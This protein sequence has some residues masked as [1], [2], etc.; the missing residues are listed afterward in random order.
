MVHIYII[1]LFYYFSIF[2]IIINIIV[3]KYQVFENELKLVTSY[4]LVS[5]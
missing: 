4:Q 2:I 5:G 3:Y 1:I